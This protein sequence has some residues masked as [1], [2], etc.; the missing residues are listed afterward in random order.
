MGYAYSFDD[1]SVVPSVGLSYSRTQSDNVAIAATPG[2]TLVFDDIESLVGFASVSVAKTIILPDQKSAI[3]P[4]VTA[5]IYNDFAD[6]SVI[7]YIAPSG[8]STPTFTENL[9]TY[10]EISAG[11]NYRNILNK[12][13]GPLRDVTASLRGDVSFSDRLLGGRVTANLRLQF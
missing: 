2:G 1:I 12:E 11:I 9:G 4:F 10:G 3:Q 6:D 8:S 5:T 13:N 7:N